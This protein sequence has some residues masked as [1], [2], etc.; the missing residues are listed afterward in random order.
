MQHGNITV[1]R[2]GPDSDVALFSLGD[3]ASSTDDSSYT[4][5]ALDHVAAVVDDLDAAEARI[6]DAGHV[7]ENHANNQPGQRFYFAEENDIE[8]GVVHYPAA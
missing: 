2:V 4:R 6:R 3:A 7:T 8:I 1:A 5:G